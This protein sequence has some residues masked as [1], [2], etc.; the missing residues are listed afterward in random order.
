V[1]KRNIKLY[2]KKML[3]KIIN[4]IK[5][6]KINPAKNI[7]CTEFE[8]DNWNISRFV[9]KKLIPVV[10]YRPF[11]LSEL[12]LL[13][14]AVCYFKPTH[15]FEWGTHI[16]KSARVFYETAK[17]FNI[18]VLIHSIDLPDNISHIEHPGYQRG[19]IVKGLKNIIL[20]QGD[21][22]DKSLEIIKNISG[23]FNP[24]FYI[25]GDHSYESVKRELS[26]II[27]TVPNA[28]ILLHDTFYQSNESNY[29]IGPFKAISEV[30]NS[31]NNLYKKIQIN[32]GLPGMT[33]LY[34][35]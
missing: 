34:K 33:L 25:D 26:G 10:G 29:N 16:G 20:H 7:N 3:Q 35:K 30:L 31:P 2:N 1:G 22:L 17:Y 12:C 24:L 4:K 18:Q 11:P 8:V 19:K 27:E 5:E 32:T 23:D 28:V 13:S 6:K 14:S 9:L 15:I 21:G